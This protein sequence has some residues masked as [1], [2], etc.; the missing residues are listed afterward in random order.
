MTATEHLIAAYCVVGLGLGLYRYYLWRQGV[1][2]AR[3][4]SA[5]VVDR[6][7]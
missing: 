4:L 7:D 2:L 6:R 3:R 1:E 5:R